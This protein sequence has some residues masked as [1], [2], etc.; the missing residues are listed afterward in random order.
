MGEARRALADAVQLQYT[1]RI[2]KKNTSS[3]KIVRGFLVGARHRRALFLSYSRA[4]VE[5]GHYEFAVAGRCVFDDYDADG[6]GFIVN[7]EVCLHL[8]CPYD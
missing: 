5:L 8:S 1:D 4:L 3:R 7:N 2:G 6:V